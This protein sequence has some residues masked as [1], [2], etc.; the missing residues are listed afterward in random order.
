MNSIRLR[1]ELKLA[2]QLYPSNFLISRLRTSILMQHGSKVIVQIFII[3]FMK[4]SIH[5]FCVKD[6]FYSFLFLLSFF[7]SYTWNNYNKNNFLFKISKKQNLSFR[8]LQKEFFSWF[9]LPKNFLAKY[10]FNILCLMLHQ[11]HTMLFVKFTQPTSKIY[12][13]ENFISSYCIS[14]HIVNYSK[15]GMS[16]TALRPIR[17]LCLQI[18]FR[19]FRQTLSKS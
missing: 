10:F 6:F 12:L 4:Y 13:R 19:H 14:F 11:W 17:N 15:N 8:I 16:T 3:N 1:V 5:L 2:C 9:F 7:P 18:S